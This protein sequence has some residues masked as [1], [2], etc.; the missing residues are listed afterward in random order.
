MIERKA[1]SK[2]KLIPEHFDNVKKQF[3]LDIKQLVDLE[4]IPLALITNWDQTAINYVPPGS[5]HVKSTRNFGSPLG[6]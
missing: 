4:M 6:F 5:F 2:N 3:L 1:C